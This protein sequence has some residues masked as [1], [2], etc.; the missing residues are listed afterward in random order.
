MKIKIYECSFEKLKLIR[1]FGI[2]G[3]MIPQKN[4]F[5]MFGK[6]SYSVKQITYD[7]E[8]GIIEIV[9]VEQSLDYTK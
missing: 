6:F 5:I 8:I 1:E 9:V 7:Y 2:N 3:F 4:S